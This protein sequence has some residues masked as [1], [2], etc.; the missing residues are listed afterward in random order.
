MPEY[1]LKNLQN[2]S[3]IRGI[4]LEGVENE[5]STSLPKRRKGL[6]GHLAAGFHEKREKGENRFA[7]PWAATRA[8]RRPP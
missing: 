1:P 4:A 6:P 3:D 5:K 8:F 2:G 7:F